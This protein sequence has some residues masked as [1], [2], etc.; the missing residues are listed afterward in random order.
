M[1][2]RVPPSCDQ[3]DGVIF[4]A[5][6][7]GNATNVRPDTLMYPMVRARILAVPKGATVLGPAEHGM[8]TQPAAG[9]I[10]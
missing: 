6:A 5:T 7:E 2:W 1:I 3:M 8:L 4:N 10:N 9:D